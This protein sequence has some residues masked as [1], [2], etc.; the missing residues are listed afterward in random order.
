[1][2]CS[3]DKGLAAGL[4]PES[5]SSQRRTLTSSVAQELVLALIHFNTFINYI[6]SGVA[7]TLSK[8][9]DDTKVWGDVSG[10]QRSWPKNDPELEQSFLTDSITG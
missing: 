2:D 10:T 6:N 1:M 5:S 7:Y 9:A 3:T 8:L 4:N